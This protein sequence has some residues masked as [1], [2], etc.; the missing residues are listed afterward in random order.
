V[1]RN[2]GDDVRALMEDWKRERPTLDTTSLPVFLP[3]RE[4]LLDADRRRARILARYG[5]TGAM[6]DVL[7][8]LRRSGEPYV[9]TPSD[10]AAALVLTPAGVSQRLDRLE[11]AGLIRRST[12]QDDRRVVSVTLTKAGV[13]LLDDLMDEYMVHE[14]RLLHQLSDRDRALLSRLLIK[15]TGS[16]ADA[17]E[18]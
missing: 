16:I 14:E 2:A 13:R 15:L 5:I 6:L 4:A 10:L 12:R 7:V 8:G 17:E 18:L 9:R 1:T 11:Q 3:L